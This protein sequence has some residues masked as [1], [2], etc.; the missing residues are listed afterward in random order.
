MIV[1]TGFGPYG[2]TAVNPSWLAA[3]AVAAAGPVAGMPVQAVEL[4][5]EYDRLEGEI[6]ALL[7][8]HKPRAVVSL[9]LWP[10]EACVRLE[11]TAANLLDFEIPDNAGA[12]VQN[13]AVAEG[14]VG[15]F[16]TRAPVKEMCRQ[17]LDDGIPARVSYSAGS[18]L[19]NAVSYITSKAIRDL[20]LDTVFLFV[21]VPYEPEQVAALIRETPALGLEL[22]Q[23][24]DL[25]SMSRD[26][27]VRA[28]QMIVARLADDAARS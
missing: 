7:T 5:V 9:G 27:V 13:R 18:Y 23:R 6:Q 21:H 10:G 15:G 14:D 3:Q 24:A 11:K 20:G 25:A 26:T 22:H 8:R 1:I 16:I 12:L 28:L 19:C 4:P 2:R 17:L